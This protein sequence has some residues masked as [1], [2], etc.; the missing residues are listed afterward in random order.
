MFPIFL[1]NNVDQESHFYYYY[2]LIVLLTY[3][4]IDRALLISKS[5]SRWIGWSLQFFTSSLH[6]DKPR[7]HNLVLD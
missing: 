4:Y 1:T 5:K 7:V 6:G 2:V 3:T